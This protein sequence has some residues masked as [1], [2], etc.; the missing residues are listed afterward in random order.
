MYL[1]IGASVP[2]IL[3]A[4]C[5]WSNKSLS[6]KNLQIISASSFWYGLVFFSMME[7][8]SSVTVL[9]S[10]GM[11]N[12]VSYHSLTRSEH[13]VSW[14]TGLGSQTYLCF[15]DSGNT[16]SVSPARGHK[17][18]CICPMS[19]AY[20]LLHNFHKNISLKIINDIFHRFMC[21]PP[22]S[23]PKAYTLWC[24]E[25]VWRRWVLATSKTWSLWNKGTLKE[26]GREDANGD[27]VTRHSENPTYVAVSNL[28]YSL[29]KLPLYSAGKEQ[30]IP[31]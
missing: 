4:Y 12:H 16:T 23:E 2:F 24:T 31:E 5:L 29:K 13:I 30:Y 22:L 11:D 19:T 18:H 26:P 25:V 9:L 17:P 10:I 1:F 28:V 14:I 8:D 6:S 21:F 15:A 3:T 27:A 7:I 20:S